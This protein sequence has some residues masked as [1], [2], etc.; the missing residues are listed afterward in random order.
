MLDDAAPRKR[1]LAA[2]LVVS[3]IVK[4]R[5]SSTPSSFATTSRLRPAVVDAAVEIPVRLDNELAADARSPNV[6]RPSLVAST[7][8]SSEP[9]HREVLGRTVVRRHVL[10]LAGGDVADVDVAVAAPLADP[11]D[12]DARPVGR[13]RLDAAVAAELED[14]LLAAAQ[15]A[16]DDVEVDAVATVRRVREHVARRRAAFGG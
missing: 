16:R 11:L 6:S 1:H 5:A 13:D 9:L 14:A 3:R 7:N 15:V 10:D 2:E 12:G 8:W 4:R